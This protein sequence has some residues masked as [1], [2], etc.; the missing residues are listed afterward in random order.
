MKREWQYSLFVCMCLVAYVFY[1]ST[2]E[3]TVLFDET[4]QAELSKQSPLF[5][6]E[7]LVGISVLLQP[8]WVPLVVNQSLILLFGM[9]A[10]SFRVQN[11]ILHLLLA[12]LILLIF[13]F[14]FDRLPSAS[15]AYERKNRIVL[16]AVGLFLL[17]PVQVQ[18]ALNILQMRLEGLLTLFVLLVLGSF[19]RLLYDEKTWYHSPWFYLLL[20]M[21]FL[22]IGTRES[23][24][25]VPFL[26][27]LV[28]L[29]LVVRGSLQDLKKRSYFYSVYGILFLGMYLLVN[30]HIS[31]IDLLLGKMTVLS[32]PG[33]LV[34]SSYQKTVSSYEYL[35]TQFP[36]I[37]HYLRVFLFPF[38]LCWDYHFPLVTSL[39]NK[40][41]ISSFLG[42]GLLGFLGVYFWKIVKD[43]V[44]P[45]AMVWFLVS[46]IP[47]SSLMPSSELVADYKTFL[48]SVGVMLGISYL[49]CFVLEYLYKHF[50]EDQKKFGVWVFWI[51]LVGLFSGVMQLSANQKELWQDPVVFWRYVCSK[52]PLRARS[53]Y[54]LGKALITS[55]QQD[56]GMEC[57]FKAIT[58]D[59]GYAD[60]LIGLGEHYLQN[61]DFNR[62]QNY[63]DR[64][65]LCESCNMRRVFENRAVL[66]LSLGK[67]QE[68]MACFEKA[69]EFKE[70]SADIYFKYAEVLKQLRRFKPAY[71]AINIALQKSLTPPA[72]MVV[73][74]SRLAFE[75]GNYSDVVTC[76]ETIDPTLFDIA[77]QFVLAASYYRLENYKKSADLFGAVYHKRPD[78]LDVVYNYAQALMQ[79][80]RYSLA[81]P[82]FQQC[83]EQEKYPFAQ[84]HAATCFYKNGNTGAARTLFA[85]LD[86]KE[87]LSD[88][89]RFKL[90]SL[91]KDF[92]IA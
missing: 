6:D 87:N 64:A 1:A 75:L 10:Q 42:F 7:G 69:I 46:L 4:V 86:T 54:H 25:V 38:Q 76:L 2:F 34:V 24:I 47:R 26:L 62:A 50:S 12:L 92:L 27:F 37:F 72:D 45:F 67:P 84:L 22:L 60:P 82:L 35:L 11:F 53:Y 89:V 73:L 14:I 63:F 61:N 43:D 15:W 3:S 56:E 9:S 31:L 70:C 40:L 88:P 13:N 52:T 49:V 48:S 59:S 71:D 28:D 8:R 78:N 5:M 74:K 90:E 29:F 32:A 23:S 91:K 41:F 65:E 21:S 30:S 55:G 17:H 79:S 58:L 77:T 80:E 51:A 44:L 57:F 68:S 66:A 85:K 19:I 16:F 81:I 20:C 33:C 36:V 39:A 18:T 83:V